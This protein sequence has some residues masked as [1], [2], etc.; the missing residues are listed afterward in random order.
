MKTLLVYRHGESE[1]NMDALAD[2]VLQEVVGGRASDSPLTVP[3]GREH[4]LGVGRRLLYLKQQGLILPDKLRL[5]SSTAVRACQT[6]DIAR[7]FA[8][9]D[10]DVRY[11][12]DLEEFDQGAW[13]GLPKSKP[14][15]L[16]D[17]SKVE[18][19][20][21]HERDPDYS[22][23]DCETLRDTTLR[24]MN[25]LDEVAGTTPEGGVSVVSGH[26]ITNRLAAI[27]VTGAD[28]LG[29]KMSFGAETCFTIEDQDQWSVPYVG[30]PTHKPN[31]PI[32]QAVWHPQ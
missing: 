15:V 5:V 11:Y 27:A 3:G 25:V 32:E 7:E 30:L 31:L 17:G 6:L 4:A 26:G 14:L 19:L 16:D 28:I 18:Y 29:T 23:G 9:L 12:Q 22:V 10:G 24:V 13:T 8:G 20:P 1:K 21:L 2:G